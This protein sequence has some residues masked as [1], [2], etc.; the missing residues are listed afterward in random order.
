MAKLTDIQ[1]L[2]GQE[3]MVHHSGCDPQEWLVGKL[4][5]YLSPEES[6]AHG[7]LVLHGTKPLGF[8]EVSYNV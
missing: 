3:V 4:L 7:T 1:A 2:V 8:P 6:K 5:A